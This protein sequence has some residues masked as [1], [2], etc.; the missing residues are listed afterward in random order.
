[1]LKS[2]LF[3]RLIFHSIHIKTSIKFLSLDIEMK[4]LND[5][6]QFTKALIL[7]DEYKTK[8]P[9][10]QSLTQALKACQKLEDFQRGQQIIKEYSSSLNL[11]DY[12]LLTS[13]IHLL[14][15]FN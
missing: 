4:K 8:N 15:K 6:N 1:M 12:Y 10:S 11:N 9:S 3:D 14:S 5:Q 13:M 7:F 2:I